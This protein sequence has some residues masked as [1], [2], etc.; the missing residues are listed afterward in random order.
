V[1]SD[2]AIQLSADIKTKSE[3]AVAN[4]IDPQRVKDYIVALRPFTVV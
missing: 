4:A 1:F 3:E 2:F